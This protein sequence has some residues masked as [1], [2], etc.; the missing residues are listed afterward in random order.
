MFQVMPRWDKR[1]EVLGDVFLKNTD[2]ALERGCT[3]VVMTPY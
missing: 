2:M 3:Y 1:I